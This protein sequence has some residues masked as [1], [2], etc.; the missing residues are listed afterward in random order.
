MQGCGSSLQRA[1][2]GTGG[3]D[4][5]RLQSVWHIS[6]ARPRGADAA[7]MLQSGGSLP[8]CLP[9]CG[10]PPQP[11][12]EQPWPG[13]LCWAGLGQSPLNSFLP[14]PTCGAEA[15][16]PGL[17]PP[18]ASC[19]GASGTAGVASAQQPQRHLQTGGSGVDCPSGPS[20]EGLQSPSPGQRSCPTHTRHPPRPWQSAASS[21]AEPLPCGDASQ[22][23]NGLGHPL[24]ELWEP[25]PH[26]ESPASQPLLPPPCW[27]V[28]SRKHWPTRAPP[29]PGLR[30]LLG[31]WQSSSCLSAA[32][33]AKLG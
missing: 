5:G 11:L 19:K 23:G 22:A 28:A 13:P 18:P 9:A 14:G 20:V 7:G 29:R 12:Q 31:G 8:A 24:A 1:E 17:S 25:S 21:G 33:D 10:S 2:G 4:G 32:G 3:A 6:C 16:P 30:R 15:A 26:G 27:H